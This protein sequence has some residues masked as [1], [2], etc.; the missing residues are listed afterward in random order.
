MRKIYGILFA[1][2]LLVGLVACN[3]GATDD[4]VLLRVPDDPTV[5]FK[6]WFPVGS[7]DDPEGK[8]GL[9]YLTGQMLSDGATTKNSYEEILRKLY[10]LASSYSVRV[11]REMT[12]LTGRTHRDNL[13]AFYALYTDAY[14]HPQ[15]KEEDFDRLKTNALNYL[16]NQLRYAQDEEL[17][18]A[19]LHDFVFE[20]TRYA[21]PPQGRVRSLEAMTVDD[22]KGFY[23]K[24]Y[25]RGNATIALGGG[26]DN[27]LVKR[28]RGSLQGLPEAQQVERPTIAPRAIEGRQVR[29]VA[30]ADAD[31]SISFGFP[32]EVKRG[33][34]DFYALWIANSWL[35]E[36]RNSSSHLFQVIRERR[37]MNYGDYSYIEAFPQ[38]GYRSFPPT[39]V[40]RNHQLFE[41][42]I[43]TLP[44][45][46]AHFALRAAM[47]EVESLVNDGM[48]EEE[49]E[50]TRGFLKKYVLHFADTTTTRLAYAVDDRFYGIDGEGH[51]ARFRKMMDE[52]TRDEVNAALKK[53]LRVDRLK[54]AVVTGDA[55]GFAA[56]LAAEA[57]SPMTYASEKSAEILAEDGEIATYALGIERERIDT[58]AID[59][60]FER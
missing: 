54:I 12:V 43:R 52:I 5:T 47:R 7:Q 3:P 35:G 26:F 1:A 45:K 36:H 28:F 37:G 55:E 38:G 33:E 59:S 42:W 40:A 25:N 19:T 2:G 21:H 15:F 51:L 14:L 8:E 48:T 27:A 4:T 31:S 39:H 53:H 34:R 56:A 50:L 60:V 13:E 20:G 24:H 18:K 32:I 23:Q 41:V 57:E 22:V 46:Q 30:K 49:F 17:A 6:V 44:N 29:L 11:D 58:V 9:A 10:P 16:K